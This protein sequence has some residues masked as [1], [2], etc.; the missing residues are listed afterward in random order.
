MHTVIVSFAS[1]RH[2]Y[3]CD[4]CGQEQNGHNDEK[5]QGM[6]KPPTGWMVDLG[7]GHQQANQNPPLYCSVECR[8]AGRK[9]TGQIPFMQRIAEAQFVSEPD[10]ADVLA[11]DDDVSELAA[12]AEDKGAL[13]AASAD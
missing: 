9:I 13:V 8:D 1:D 10:A 2:V 6:V 12:E 11:P 3:G 5:N 4:Y 7:F